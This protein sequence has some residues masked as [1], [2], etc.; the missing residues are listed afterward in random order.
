MAHPSET[1]LPTVD[2]LRDIEETTTVDLTAEQTVVE[3]PTWF[4]A[5]RRTEERQSDYYLG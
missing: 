3:L 1:A 5:E 4:L 2:D